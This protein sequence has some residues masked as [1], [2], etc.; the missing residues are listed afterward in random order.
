M[1]GVVRPPATSGREGGTLTE[2][3]RRRHRDDRG[4]PS[5]RHVAHDR[6]SLPGFTRVDRSPPVRDDKRAGPKR[7]EADMGMDAALA[8]VD[9]AT[10]RESSSNGRRPLRIATLTGA[11]PGKWI[12]TVMAPALVLALVPAPM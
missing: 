10:D 6:I 3:A 2:D 8:V 4:G 12:V 11:G 7:P 5:I 9:R 1:V